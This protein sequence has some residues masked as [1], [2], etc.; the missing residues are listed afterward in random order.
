[1]M[2][3]EKSWSSQTEMITSLKQMIQDYNK[4]GLSL[5]PA[6]L[7]QSIGAAEMEI[8]ILKA[9]VTG[10]KKAQATR[11]IAHGPAATK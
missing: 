4:L 9:K 8:E 11:V 7:N 3:L 6:E 5:S 1:M 2:L 10:L